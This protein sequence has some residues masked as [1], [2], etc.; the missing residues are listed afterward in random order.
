MPCDI[1]LVILF[2]QTS[3]SFWQ[4]WAIL[5]CTVH[6]SNENDANVILGSVIVPVEHS[7]GTEITTKKASESIKLTLVVYY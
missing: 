6:L 7:S 5:V 3:G 2:V 4:N 1:S